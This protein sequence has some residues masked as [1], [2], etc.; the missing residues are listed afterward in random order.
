MYINAAHTAATIS[1]V[2]SANSQGPYNAQLNLIPFLGAGGQSVFFTVTP[3]SIS[4]TGLLPGNR[5]DLYITGACTTGGQTSVRFPF[6]VAVPNDE[7]CGAT[8]LPLD[9]ATTCTPVMGFVTGATTSAP[10]GYANPGCGGLATAPDVWYKFTT[11]ATGPGSTSIVLTANNVIAASQLRVFAA[12]SCAGPFAELACSSPNASN[13]GATPLQVTGLVPNT[14]FYVSVTGITSGTGNTFTLCASALPPALPC[15]SLFAVY[16]PS[17]LLTP[18]AAS[19][20]LAAVTGS[21]APLS[22]T[23]TC[24]P[25]AGPPVV[26]TVPY[27][28]VPPPAG[29]MQ[30]YSTVTVTGLLPNTFYTASVVANCA[31][32]GPSAAVSTTFT[33]YAPSTTAANDDCATALAL[34]VSTACVP[35]LTSDVNAHQSLPYIPACGFI[36]GPDVWFSAT[37]PANGVLQIATGPAT[38]SAVAYVGVQF[39]SGTCGALTS[40]DCSTAGAFPLV[41]RT[42]LMPGSTVYGRAWQPGS[43]P[44]GPFTIC[45][46]TDVT[47]PLATNLA[48]SALTTT[49]ATLTFTL[50]A[51]NAGY[52]LTYTPAGGP[53]Q[54]QTVTGSPVVLTGLTPGKAYTV[55]LTGSCTGAGA[56]TVRTSFTTPAVPSCAAPSAVYVGNLGA[57]T[58]GIGFVTNAAASSYTATYQAA[59]GPVQTVSPAPTASP[60]LLTGLVPGT[61]YT[62][63]V[64]STCPNGLASAPVCATM[65]STPLASRTAALA[66]QVSLFPNPASRS[67]TLRVPAALRGP[68]ASVRLLNALGQV[69]RRQPLAAADTA[70]DLAGLPTGLYS[71]LLATPQGPLVKRLVVE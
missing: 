41:R 19:I 12:P 49:S 53:A 64:A 43:G 23:I 10:N 42:G 46:T 14:T 13:V 9:T 60:V 39:F 6:T 71:L 33:T 45:A 61:A 65:F 66:A 5:Y 59:G 50:P 47:C 58:A 20:S 54:T 56:G 55:A 69:V 37:V 30:V 22:Y 28:P 2:P 35:T 52:V 4:L 21:A 63:C 18:T 17:T 31:S 26:L 44:G 3:P 48:A 11:A 40:L 36:P 34:P 32:G 27:A 68:G 1:F 7:P 25:A 8:P 15:A 24:T 67:A 70:L 16:V 38:G 57:T 29:S 62:V 51:G